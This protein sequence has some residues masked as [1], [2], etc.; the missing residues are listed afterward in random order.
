MF[1]RNRKSR[2]LTIDEYKNSLVSKQVIIDSHKLE[3][4]KYVIDA[5]YETNHEYLDPEV[6]RKIRDLIDYLW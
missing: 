4:I 1:N 6:D 2:P 5:Y 3:D